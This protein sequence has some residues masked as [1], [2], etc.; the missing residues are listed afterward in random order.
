MSGNIATTTRQPLRAR[1]LALMAASA[2]YTVS[3]MPG[4]L[5]YRMRLNATAMKFTRGR[6]ETMRNGEFIGLKF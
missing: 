3:A 6:G 2:S 5:S 4:G 1:T